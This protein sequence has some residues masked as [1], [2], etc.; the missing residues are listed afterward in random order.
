ME[1]AIVKL[2]LKTAIITCTC[3]IGGFFIISVIPSQLAHA[4]NNIS[5]NTLVFPVDAKPYGKSYAEWSAIWWQWLLSIPKDISPAGDTTGKNC[6]TN[7][8]GPIWFLAG[9]FGGAAEC[10]CTI[11]SGK[12][13]MF[14]PINSECSYAEYPDEKTESDLLECAKTFQD[15]TTYAQVTITGTAIE[16]LDNF[17][18]QSPPFN[19]TF[20]ENNV[21]GI[22]PGQTQSVSDGI[23]I[24]L[25]PLPPGE[26]KIGFKGIS[27][28][29]TTGAKNTFVSD[30]SYNVIVR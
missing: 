9:T 12:A 15:Q 24:I 25:K 22:S 20:P 5:H 3:I 8:Q 7:Q 23:W 18:I 28:D 11:P 16:N 4:Q 19:V 27:V 30:A 26:H 21:F 10:T 29:F 17:R 14:S 2:I 13:I 1:F 6:G